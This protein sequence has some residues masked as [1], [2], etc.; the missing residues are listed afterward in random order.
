M[1]KDKRREKH[2]RRERHTRREKDK[3]LEEF[4]NGIGTLCS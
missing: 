2:T 1:K 4:E 3:I